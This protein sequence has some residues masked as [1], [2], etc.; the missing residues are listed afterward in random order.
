MKLQSFIACVAFVALGPTAALATMP[1]VID[2]ISS[3]GIGATTAGLTMSVRNFNQPSRVWFE[4]S[5]HANLSNPTKVAEWVIA[6]TNN[7][8]GWHAQLSGLQPE[9]T[10]YFRA[11]ARNYDGE[12]YSR[13]ESFRTTAP[14]KVAP[15][16]SWEKST[17]GLSGLDVQ[18]VCRGHGAAGACSGVWSLSPSMS[19][20][21]QFSWTA[22]GASP[23]GII[24]N[25]HL[26]ITAVPDNT[27]IYVQGRIGTS[28][29]EGKTDVRDFVIRNKP[30]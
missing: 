24:A 19:D 21:H 6:A 9:T 30:I 11:F 2:G 28:S 25:G 3:W 20:A 7:G 15:T 8:S 27:H 17:L 10:Y 23:T 22:V 26:P 18:F 12:T 4:Y 29:G 5:T 1:V 16:M 14:S 13:I